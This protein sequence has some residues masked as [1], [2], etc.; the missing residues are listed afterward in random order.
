MQLGGKPGLL[1]GTL[2][3]PR[4]G[5]SLNQELQQTRSNSTERREVLAAITPSCRAGAAQSWQELLLRGRPGGFIS[6][7][8]QQ[9]L[10]EIDLLRSLAGAQ[11]AK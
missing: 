3:Q 9:I 4:A 1:L 11:H 8:S 6:G 5:F 7:A 10:V 2:Q